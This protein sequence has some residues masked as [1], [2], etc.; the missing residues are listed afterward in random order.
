MPTLP[1]SHNPRPCDFARS[2]AHQR[3]YDYA[4]SQVRD[5]RRSLSP[6]CVRC[7]AKDLVTAVEIVDHIIP[8]VIR[9][10]L[11]LRIDNTQ[12][13]CRACHADKTAEDVRSYGSR[14]AENDAKCSA[15][16]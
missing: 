8:V 7:E 15:A 3:G 2:R 13:L 16:R 10:D 12:S 14:V 1:P 11:R 4:W 6:F 9:P 5:R